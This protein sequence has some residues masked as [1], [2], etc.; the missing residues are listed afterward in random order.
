MILET[1]LNRS[2]FKEKK[3]NNEE[4][5]K[6]LAEDL[7]VT[8]IS[9]YN[10]GFYWDERYL[11]EYKGEKYTYVNVGSGSGYIHNHV[12]ILK[13]DPEMLEGTR[14]DGNKYDPVLPPGY[15]ER[16]EIIKAILEL[17]LSEDDEYT[18][19]DEDE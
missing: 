5:L 7:K 1:S 19:Y 17:E 4:R 12:G 14:D 18:I 8:G 2:H 11:V 16:V 9:G 6:V 3:M 13:G 10:D 15:G